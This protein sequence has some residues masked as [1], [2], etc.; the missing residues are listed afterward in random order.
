MEVTD[1]REHSTRSPSSPTH[2]TVE[3]LFP[4]ALGLGWLTRKREKEKIVNNEDRGKKKKKK[5][6]KSTISSPCLFKKRSTTRLAC[7]LEAH[8]WK[9]F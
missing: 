6:R 5:K 1:S 9:W 7:R 3:Q 2:L 8:G 4:A